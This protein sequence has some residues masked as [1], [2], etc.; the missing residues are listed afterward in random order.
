MIRS[1]SYLISHHQEC[2]VR[3]WNIGGFHHWDVEFP[4]PITLGARV[5]RQPSDVSCPVT[6]KPVQDVVSLDVMLTYIMWLSMC[7]LAVYESPHIHGLLCTCTVIQ[8]QE[9]HFNK[10]KES[11]LAEDISLNKVLSQSVHRHVDNFN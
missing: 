6:D 8:C 3:P 11:S 9:S 7:C 2:A 5:A 4:R 1:V 10:T